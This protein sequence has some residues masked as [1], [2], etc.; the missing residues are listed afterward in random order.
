MKLV[1]HLLT[2]LTLSA[3]AILGFVHVGSD[4]P[5]T[6]ATGDVVEVDHI[7]ASVGPMPS[8]AP[9]TTIQEVFSAVDVDNLRPA[10]RI[11][12]LVETTTTAA[13]IPVG[14][15]NQPFAPEGLSDCDEF[16]FYRVQW[17]L[18]ER[19]NKLAWRESNCRNE[20]GVKTYCC[21]GY[22]QLYVSYQI[23]DHRVVDRYHEC[24]VYSHEDLNSDT[25]IEKQRQLC[26]ASVLYD[27]EGFSPWA[28]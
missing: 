8:Q 19:F 7:T 23:K 17:G 5:E 2:V 26:A 20:D 14:L 6:L 28:L 27:I 13:Y 3:G 10:D 18:P 11:A 24:G 4:A 21:H 25:P 12:S 9:Y 22:L 16:N 15:W 1:R